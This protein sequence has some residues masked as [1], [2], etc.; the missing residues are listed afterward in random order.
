MN[1]ALL[2]VVETTLLVTTMAMAGA[3]GAAIG[4]AVAPFINN[5]IQTHE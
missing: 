5:Q 4:K 3:L 2:V 1:L